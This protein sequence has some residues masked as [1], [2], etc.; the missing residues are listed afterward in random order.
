MNERDRIMCETP[1]R[2]CSIPKPM[3]DRIEDIKAMLHEEV[4]GKWSEYG[5]IRRHTEGI[6]KATGKEYRQHERHMQSAH[7][8]Y[9]CP[10]LR[11]SAIWKS[12]RS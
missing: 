4:R 2:M 7:A 10:F 3:W 12:R 9:F 11:Y 5:Q 1:G 6:D 8:F